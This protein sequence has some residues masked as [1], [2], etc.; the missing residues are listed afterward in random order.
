METEGPRE[1]TLNER[2]LVLY[3]RLGT[4]YPLIIDA[5]GLPLKVIAHLLGSAA[6]R[7]TLLWTNAHPR[8]FL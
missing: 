6:R 3:E 1:H 5:L 2:Q 7:E 4:L 8:E